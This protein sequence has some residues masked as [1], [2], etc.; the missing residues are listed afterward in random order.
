MNNEEIYNKIAGS[1]LLRVEDLS[2]CLEQAF[3]NPKFSQQKDLA[4]VVVALRYFSQE[5]I[6]ELLDKGNWDLRDDTPDT[7]IDDEEDS[8][9]PTK[10]AQTLMKVDSTRKYKVDYGDDKKAKKKLRYNKE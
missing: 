1:G 6:D 3:S 4:Q 2:F 10:D 5:Q 8:F 9:V 7:I